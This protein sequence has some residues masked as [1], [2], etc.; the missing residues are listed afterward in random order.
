MKSQRCFIVLRNEKFI[1]KKDNSLNLMECSFDNLITYPNVPFHLN[2]WQNDNRHINT[3]KNFLKNDIFTKSRFSS[4]E[5]TIAVPDDSQ[6]IELRAIEEFLLI[7]SSP[8]NVNLVFECTLMN[9][10]NPTYVCI[11]KT[12]RMFVISYIKNGAITAQRFLDKKDYE[13]DEIQNIIYALHDDCRMNIINIYLNG[14]NLDKYSSFGTFIS[15]ERIL[16]NLTLAQKS[17]V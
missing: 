7:S 15:Y 10:E 17:N 2:L 16:D 6:S 11:S 8:R 13:I 9:P 1:I 3:L 4:K 14:A 5:I 12:C